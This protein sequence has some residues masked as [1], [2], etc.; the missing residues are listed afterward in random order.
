MT[1]SLWN[2]CECDLSPPQLKMNL[3]WLVHLLSCLLPCPFPVQGTDWIK[4]MEVEPLRCAMTMVKRRGRSCRFFSPTKA[5]K[6]REMWSEGENRF[7][8][9]LTPS[10]PP[11]FPL[12]L[13]AY[14]PLSSTSLSSGWDWSSSRWPQTGLGAPTAPVIL[15]GFGS[16][17]AAWLS[18]GTLITPPPGGLRTA[19]RETS[20]EREKSFC[21]YMGIIP[22]PLPS[23]QLVL[24]TDNHFQP[25]LQGFSADCTLVW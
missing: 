23:G 3:T 12:P 13:L 11:S 24:S 16:V 14:C 25:W 2:T 7:A 20:R 8:F 6:Q 18:Y 19:L 5:V 22:E 10:H 15:C 21:L 9:P 4:K 1:R 17:T